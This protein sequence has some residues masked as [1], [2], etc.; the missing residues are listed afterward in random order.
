[1]ELGMVK[2]GETFFQVIEEPRDKTA[3]GN[4]TQP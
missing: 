3:S 2:K 1:M 4:K